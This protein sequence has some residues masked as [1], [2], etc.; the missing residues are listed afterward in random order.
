LFLKGFQYHTFGN[1]L[2]PDPLLAIAAAMLIVCAILYFWRHLS[3]HW[4]IICAMAIFAALQLLGVSSNTALGTLV[5]P[6]AFT[7]DRYYFFAK[8]AF[9]ICFT[10]CLSKLSSG[11]YSQPLFLLAP[12]CLVFIAMLN[13]H[14]L[15]RPPLSD[16]HWKQASAVI[17]SGQRSVVI[18]INPAPWEIRLT[19]PDRSTQ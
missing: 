4:L 19:L 7:G 17:S 18:P 10:F 8:I 13:V 2:L 9:W 12:A 15:R 3:P 5:S 11:R 14:H 6:V 1:V 16:L